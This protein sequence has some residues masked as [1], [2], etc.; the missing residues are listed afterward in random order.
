MLNATLNTSKHL[1][2]GEEK[3]AFNLWILFEKFI[4]DFPKHIW[5]EGYSSG[6]L[7]YTDT[8]S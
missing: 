8:V 3:M 6:R 5:Y 1:I 7:L 4:L 2:K